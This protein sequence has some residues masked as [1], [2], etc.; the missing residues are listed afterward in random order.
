MRSATRTSYWLLSAFV[1]WILFSTTYHQY[2]LLQGIGGQFSSVVAWGVLCGVL[3]TGVYLADVPTPSRTMWVWRVGLFGYGLGWLLNGFGIE[4]GHALRVLWAYPLIGTACYF[5]LATHFST[6]TG[7]WY[8]RA[9]MNVAVYFS[10]MGGLTLLTYALDLRWVGGLAL[11]VNSVLGMIVFTHMMKPLTLRSENRSLSANWAILAVCLWL[12]NVSV[13]VALLTFAMPQPALMLWMQEASEWAMLGMLLGMTNQIS[14]GIRQHNRPTTGWLPFWLVA[15][16]VILPFFGGMMHSVIR[17]YMPN[18]DAN[19]FYP[20]E[21][22]NLFGGACRT[23]GIALY[24][25]AFWLRQ[26]SHFARFL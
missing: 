23:A 2:T 14:M 10:I 1:L 12:M 3:G 26:P 18:V 13:P 9:M 22:L 19:A 16:G 20:F 21:V 17:L 4:W 8:P 24:T 7:L 6:L 15:G 11:V 5:W 25:L